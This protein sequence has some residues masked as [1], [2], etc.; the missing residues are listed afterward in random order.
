[1]LSLNE[2]RMS[3]SLIEPLTNRE[4]EVLRLIAAGDTNHEIAR[5]LVISVSAVKKHTGNI[6]GKLNVNNRTQAAARARQLN[7][8]VVD[9]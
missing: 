6:F 9:E 7:L 4:L 1:M 5:K 3:E 8:L 2:E